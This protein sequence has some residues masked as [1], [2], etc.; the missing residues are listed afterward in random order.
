LDFLGFPWILSSETSLFNGLCGANA[1]KIF[2]EAFPAHLRDR[3]DSHK[4]EPDC[5]SGKSSLI[6]DLPQAIVV[7]AL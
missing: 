5:S 2:L 1:R 4:E 7:G 3:V 6:S